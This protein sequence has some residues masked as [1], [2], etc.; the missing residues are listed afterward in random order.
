MYEN[1]DALHSL[2]STSEER[3]SIINNA[4]AEVETMDTMDTM[5]RQSLD[6]VA[7]LN[8]EIEHKKALVAAIENESKTNNNDGNVPKRLHFFATPRNHDNYNGMVAPTNYPSSSG[9]P[10]KK[11]E[12]DELRNP[13]LSQERD[14]MLEGAQSIFR[15]LEKKKSSLRDPPSPLSSRTTHV[16]S[17]F[18]DQYNLPLSIPTRRRAQSVPKIR[19][20]L[21]CDYNE[22]SLRLRDEMRKFQSSVRAYTKPTCG[23]SLV[24]DTHHQVPI[25]VVK[26][27]DRGAQINTIDDNHNQLSK[28]SEIVQLRTQLD[29]MMKDRIEDSQ[30]RSKQWQAVGFESENLNLKQQLIAMQRAADDD[31]YKM[32]QMAEAY[33]V[34]MGEIEIGYERSLA[35][36]KD[37]EDLRMNLN[38]NE[39]VIR[40]AMKENELLREELH[41][42]QM[43]NELSAKATMK[44]NDFLR[45]ELHNCRH[46]NEQEIRSLKDELLDV[47]TRCKA[48]EQESESRRRIII[49]IECKYDEL[50]RKCNDEINIIKD[51][52]RQCIEDKTQYEKENS[53][54][55]VELRAITKERNNLNI[56]MDEL[57]H[58]LEATT[59][60]K[61]DAENLVNSTLR[62]RENNENELYREIRQLQDELYDAN[63]QRGVDERE[64]RLL[65]NKLIAA[66]E[67]FYVIREEMGVAMEERDV[68]KSRLVLVDELTNALEVAI[69]NDEEKTLSIERLKNELQCAFD[70]KAETNRRHSELEVEYQRL[71]EMK[72]SESDLTLLLMKQRDSLTAR[73]ENYMDEI[74]SMRQERGVEIL[75]KDLLKDELICAL[76]TATS[77]F[78]QLTPKDLDE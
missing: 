31:A 63:T 68:M 20:D 19:I 13:P 52:H 60:K 36:I 70:D 28:E 42:C 69:A 21:D 77:I 1:D 37:G 58:R 5:Q 6:T 30:L 66:Q 15:I 67:E 72:D 4:D 44:E 23:P 71:Q 51:D 40:A 73:I 35:A 27:V 55:M 38:D 78:P 9:L 7:S 61:E 29:D 49:N 8:R 16:S 2:Q 18:R 56:M 75:E 45:E 74:D 53:G 59:V 46:R 11:N 62:Q 57:S 39:R 54:L 76:E 24:P 26:T 33:K 32:T 22:Y 50:K 25:K 47:N 3:R 10:E 17:E 34:A 14:W 48:A 65:T 12:V 41:T 64:I 43:E